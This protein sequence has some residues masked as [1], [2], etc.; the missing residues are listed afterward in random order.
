MMFEM[1]GMGST[2]N[3]RSRTTSASDP[4]GRQNSQRDKES[5]TSRS[6]LGRRS[7]VGSNSSTPRSS[8]SANKK[9][10]K[11][12]LR[13]RGGHC[14]KLGKR[15]KNED[16]FVVFPNIHDRSYHEEENKLRSRNHAA[17]L[18]ASSSGAV[19]SYGTGLSGLSR[20]LMAVQPT[21]SPE[22]V[23]HQYGGGSEKSCA[24]FAVYDGHCGDSASIFCEQQ[25][26]DHIYR[27]DRIFFL[28][29][30]QC[31]NSFHRLIDI[32]NFRL[33]SKRQL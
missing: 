12:G 10:G 9:L 28:S 26:M 24:F 6:S 22:A 8:F 20:S 31:K 11:G 25:L 16:R 21:N 27:Y 29:P 18:H 23:K 2:P 3:Q 17:Q 30:S 14:S 1:D 33:T 19:G 4:H 7:P 15:E 5:T 32:L 13:W